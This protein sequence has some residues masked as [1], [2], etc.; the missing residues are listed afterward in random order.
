MKQYFQ[1]SKAADCSGLRLLPITLG[2]TAWHLLVVIHPHQMSLPRHHLKK[3]DRKEI[4]VKFYFGLILLC[5][6]EI[7]IVHLVKLINVRLIYS[8]HL[9]IILIIFKVNRIHI[10]VSLEE[11]NYT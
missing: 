4:D 2:K 1:K 5:I 7:S 9:H 11:T 3:N 6:A 10:S 8:K